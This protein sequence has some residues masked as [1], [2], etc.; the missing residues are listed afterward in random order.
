VQAN[1][2]DDAGDLPNPWAGEGLAILIVR[3]KPQGARLIISEQE[4][5]IGRSADVHFR[6]EDRHVSR[7]HA[8]ISRER[9]GLRF[10]CLPG[11]SPVLIGDVETVDGVA[12][13]GTQV[14]V[15]ETV[16]AVESLSAAVETTDVKL[17][18][19]GAAAEV[20][21]LSA[22]VAL[23]EALDRAK[24]RAELPDL[25]LAWG[26]RQAPVVRV[27]LVEE[28]ASQDQVT[29]RSGE[30]TTSVLV[31]AHADLHVSIA[32]E[33]QGAEFVVGTGLLRL[34]VVAG[35]VC[36]STL[37]RLDA[38]ES[39]EREKETLRALAVGSSRSFLGSSEAA[40]RVKTLVAR[41]GDS[42]AVAL[43]E[44]ETGV[45]KTFVARLIHEAGPRARSPL[46]VVNCAAIPENLVESELFGHERGAFTGATSSR[47]GVFES[48]GDGTVL[49]DEIGELPG[50]SQSKLLHVL[51]DK[52]FT[53]VGSSRRVPLRARVLVATNRN[54]DQMV[55]QGTFRHDLFFRVSVVRLRIPPLRERGEDLGLLA[56]HILADLAAS[57]LRRVDAFSD[58]AL[59]VI[60]RY[61]WPGNVRELRNVIEHALVLGDG[62]RILPSDLPSALRADAAAASRS[63]APCTAGTDD[64]AGR[65]RVVELPASL[66]WLEKKAIEAA[67]EATEGNRNRAAAILGIN[68]VTLY[69]KLRAEPPK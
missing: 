16:L 53:R 19:Q 9:G 27:K 18:L 45:G 4:C 3:G 35:R 32:F 39:I 8:R 20:V 69:K 34:L 43:I 21:G 66:E 13:V 63:A 7:K 31:P 33:L 62:R 14:I 36:G 59:D 68:R 46:L 67:L 41:L 52:A 22:L 30:G 55:E 15:G 60:R 56:K 50:A 58:E 57:S 1:H 40:S 37:A 65:P 2:S 54:L 42:D 61:P 51:E 44:G 28:G 24:I 49:L 10:R 12:A 17:L 5:V 23:T 11:A 64:S 48:A 26:L 38:M 47:R 25:L 6:V 29:V